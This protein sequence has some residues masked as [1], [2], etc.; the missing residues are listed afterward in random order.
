TTAARARKEEASKQ[1]FTRFKESQ[2]PSPKT[3]DS[4]A[5]SRSEL[6]TTRSAG[7]DLIVPSASRPSYKVKP[8][9]ILVS[10]IDSYR[11]SVYIPDAGTISSRPA[12]IYNVFNSYSAR[13]VVIYQDRYNS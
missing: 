5:A 7:S 9:P 2:S 10:T 6:P 11:R 3:P 8:P 4:I 13:P 12:R 1:E